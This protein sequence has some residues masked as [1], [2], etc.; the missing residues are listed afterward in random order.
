MSRVFISYR[1]EDDAHCARVRDLATR[2]E[3]TGV[4]VVLDEFAQS[5]EFHG[6]GPN[7][8]WPRLSKQQAGDSTHKILIIASASWFRC[9]EGK[10][11]PGTGLCAAAL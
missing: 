6:G 2:L 3:R 8:G 11:L 7:E 1:R 5:R 10:E 9:Y 4:Q